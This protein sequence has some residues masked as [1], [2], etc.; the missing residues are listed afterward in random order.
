MAPLK[1]AAQRRDLFLDLAQRRALLAQATGGVRDLI[2]A[3]MCTGCRAGELTSA[4]RGAF[5]A[6]TGTLAVTGKTG[7]RTIPLAPAA[8][9][10]FQ[11]LSRDKLPGAFLFVRDDAKPWAHSDWDELVKRAATVAGLPAKTCLYTSVTASSPR[12]SWM[13]SAPWRL[14][15]SSALRSP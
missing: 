3:A 8:I 12:L 1:G 15:S 10:L 7:S 9:T 5:D 14:Q 11:R 6:R 4:R 13:A 2:E